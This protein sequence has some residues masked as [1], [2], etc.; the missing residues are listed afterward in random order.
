[1]GI[2]W[3][4]PWEKHPATAAPS[5]PGQQRVCGESARSQLQNSLFPSA[6]SV[7]S[8]PQSLTEGCTDATLMLN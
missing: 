2:S 6:V 3:H 8:S 4:F 7:P 5:A 1:M